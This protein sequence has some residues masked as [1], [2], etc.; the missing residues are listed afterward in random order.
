MILTEGGRSAFPM[1][2]TR[3]GFKEIEDTSITSPEGSRSTTVWEVEA[4][5]KVVYTKDELSE[6]EYVQVLGDE[7]DS[8]AGIAGALGDL[9]TYE[10]EELLDSYRGADSVDKKALS[11]I[12]VGVGAPPVM[13]EEFCDC[14][15]EALASDEPQL[16]EAGLWGASF[17]AVREFI[18]FIEEIARTEVDKD[19]KETAE[20]MLE[21]YHQRG[22][23]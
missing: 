3:M 11:L 4:G 5:L 21:I 14:I 7:P 1:L 9:G 16:R 23:K 19:M 15:I 12:R 18:P 20:L 6:T 17:Y 2:A 13:D 8:V 22:L 10:Y